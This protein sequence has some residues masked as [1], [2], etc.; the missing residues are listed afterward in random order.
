MV[1]KPMVLAAEPI[2]IRVCMK[3]VRTLTGLNSIRPVVLAHPSLVHPQGKF[4]RSTWHFIPAKLHE[5]VSGLQVPLQA[6]P[7]NSRDVLMSLHSSFSYPSIFRTPAALSLSSLEDSDTPCNECRS[8]FSCCNICLCSLLCSKACSARS[9]REA[10][11]TTDLAVPTSRNRVGRLARRRQVLTRDNEK[12]R[13]Q[14]RAR[15]TEGPSEFSSVWA[16]LFDVTLPLPARRAPALRP[17]APR[18]PVE[19]AQARSVSCE[20]NDT[21]VEAFV[22][23]D[24]DDT[25]ARS[26]STLKAWIDKSLPSEHA[27]Y[28]QQTIGRLQLIYNDSLS[29]YAGGLCTYLSIK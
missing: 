4:N 13:W 1:S 19:L 27:T 5:Q 12:D 3:C 25:A 2:L 10:T 14:T 16:A 6:Q 18:P 28:Y 24:K 7:Q 23:C 15:C 29:K 11:F 20:C 9:H 22:G 26:L 8:L 17:S 21:N